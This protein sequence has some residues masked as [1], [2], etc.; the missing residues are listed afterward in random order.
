MPEKNRP[1]SRVIRVAVA[2]PLP[3]LFDYLCTSDVLPG[4]RVR[5]SFGRRR[6]VAVVVAVD[7]ESEHPV[8]QLK[9]VEAVLDDAP[10]LPD[11][12]MQLCAWVA[13]YYH[14]PPGEVYATALPAALRRGDVARLTPPDSWQLTDEGRQLDL[15]ALKRAPRQQQLLARLQKSDGPLEA[16]QLAEELGAIR[17]ALKNLYDK[18]W[19]ERAR[20]SGNCKEASPSP[21]LN[22][23]QHAAVEAVAAGLGRFHP[24][25]LDGVT[26]SGKTEVYL[27]IIRRVLSGDQQA[28]VLVP[29]IALTPQLVGRFEKHLGAEVA[30][31]HSG[32]TDLERM[33]AWLLAARG[34]ISV[35]IGTRSAVFTP[36]AR[37]GVIIVDEEH[38]GSFKQQDGLR[39]SA[40]D[41]AV[42]RAQ[43]QKIPV[44]LGS[45]TPA[46]ESL[47]NALQGRYQHLQLS[48]RAGGAKPPSMQLIDIR[49][50]KLR[51]GLSEPLMVAMQHHLDANGQVMLFLNRR[52]FSPILMCH[53]CGWHAECRR[54]DTRMTYHRR[55]AALRCHH[56]G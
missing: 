34:D 52:G 25:L 29:E 50:A 47:N 46:L 31:L 27:E 54:C 21:E 22:D 39:Y 56:C 26:G 28:L 40:R 4:V 2:A 42:R 14:H 17:P 43:L 20:K 53:A 11:Q 6:T 35:V 37:P 49:R 23:D 33:Q 55:T 13:S 41:V 10:I 8:N 44:I 18:G 7:V 45:A 15:N 16:S 5:V 32:L 30:V 12:L 3:K 24:C 36:L 48:T 9:A 1:G 38:D 51:E 19:V